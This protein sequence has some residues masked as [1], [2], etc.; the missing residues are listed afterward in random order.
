[1]SD[2]TKAH[3]KDCGARTNHE[4][5]HKE[6][7]NWTNE[8]YG[9]HGWV[10]YQMLRCC[11]CDRIN[12]RQQNWSS[13]MAMDQEAEPYESYFPPAISRRE[14]LWKRELVTSAGIDIDALMGEIYVALQNGSRR[15]AAMGVRALLEQVMIDKVGDQK[16]FGKNLKKFTDEGYLSAK[17]ADALSTIL[18]A[19]HATIHRAW[20]P[21]EADLGTLLDVTEAVLA[22]IYIHSHK[23]NRLKRKV[24]KKTK[25]TAAP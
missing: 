25:V 3:C 1:M 19:G 12:Y 22:D 11:G 17:Q 21:S 5:L 13:E 8:D 6:R 16:S 20:S 18:E 9:E 15:L 2:K 10:E 23:V 14:P 24:P 7:A 4:I